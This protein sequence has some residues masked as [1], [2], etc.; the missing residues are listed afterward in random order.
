MLVA[1][2]IDS[3]VD[4]RAVGCRGEHHVDHNAR[5]VDFVLAGQR[6]PLGQLLLVGAVAGDSL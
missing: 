4:R 1:H 3:E 2:V 6:L 5:E